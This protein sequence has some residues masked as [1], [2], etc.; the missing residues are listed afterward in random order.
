MAAP[1]VEVGQAVA[2]GLLGIC[3]RELLRDAIASDPQVVAVR[4]DVESASPSEVAFVW[5]NSRGEF[6][7]GGML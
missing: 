2:Q 6:I 4:I 7:G 1:F 5:V 3:A